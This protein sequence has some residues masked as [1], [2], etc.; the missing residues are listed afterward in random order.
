M[1]EVNRR[2][3]CWNDPCD[4]EICNGTVQEFLKGKCLKI[5]HRD[6]LGNKEWRDWVEYSL[7]EAYQE[8]QEKAEIA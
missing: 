4:P 1:S 2:C 6:M 3:P 7:T 8:E 5:L